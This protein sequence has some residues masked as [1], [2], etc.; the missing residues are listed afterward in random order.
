MEDLA[1]LSALAA[2]PVP[3]AASIA[4][5]SAVVGLLG[6]AGAMAAPRLR[7][8]WLKP[9][10]HVGRG[11]L[12]GWSSVVEIGADAG[13]PMP[14]AIS[15]VNDGESV[16]V[17]L[18]LDGRDNGGLNDEDLLA[19][20]AMRR[21]AFSW[22]GDEKVHVRVWH[23]RE[24]IE[25]STFPPKGGS[26]WVRELIAKHEARMAGTARRTRH[27]MAIT[28]SDAGARDR[29]AKA[30][31]TA[32]RFFRYWGPTV[33]DPRVSDAGPQANALLGFLAALDNPA[34]R[35][36][37]APRSARLG[38]HIAAGDVE[39]VDPDER[40]RNGWQPGLLRWTYG[41]RVKYGHVLAVPDWGTATS[42]ALMADLSTLPGEWTI[43]HH[44]KPLDGQESEALLDHLERNPLARFDRD[45]SEQFQSLR[46][47]IRPESGQRERLCRY[48]QVMYLYGDS[49][50]EAA[51]LRDA[52]E[53]IYLRHRVTALPESDLAGLIWMAQWP[54]F[55]KAAFVRQSRLT[56]LAAAALVNFENQAEGA[57]T[58][59][60]GPS[61]LLILP[62][63]S[64][65]PY[66]LVLHDNPREVASR[67]HT[68]IFGPNGSGKTVFASAM[69]Y[70]ARAHF[71]DLA[72]YCGDRKLGQLVA[73]VAAGAKYVGLLSTVP[74]L[75]PV[76]LN[77]FARQ[78]MDLELVS[79][80]KTLVGLMAGSSSIEVRKAAEAMAHASQKMYVARAPMAHRSL[81]TIAEAALAKGDPVREALA[82]FLPGG[83]Y[84]AV[85]GEGE[86]TASI[87][88]A[89]HVAFD[90][91]SV[92]DDPVVAGPVV[93]DI[94]WLMQRRVRRFGS[95]GL[96]VLDESKKLLGH[97]EFASAAKNWLE[98]LRK[99][100]VA[101]VSMWQRPGQTREVGMEEVLKS[102]TATWIFM[103]DPQATVEQYEGWLTPEEVMVVRGEDPRLAGRSRTVLV[104]KPGTGESV[105]LDADFSHLGPAINL[106]RSDDLA[107]VRFRELLRRD[108]P[109]RATSVYLEEMARRS[110]AA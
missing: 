39:E 1:G 12:Y 33:L 13:V 23:H 25:I 59:G 74:G 53:Q 75:Q 107:T 79:H 22:I 80:L 47:R 6:M 50:E 97:S 5:G 11:E 7:R 63:L 3:W 8:A 30:A 77:P 100:R 48:D 60:W 55:E 76:R 72:I 69:I 83:T 49:P 27:I 96:F 56:T 65:A 51:E 43:V 66:G 94:T 105:I 109:D 15:E 24:R 21:E 57:W 68:V 52:A 29:V 99:D 95:G 67:A 71:P 32:L 16:T 86:E 101:V 19:L 38:V 92:L 35:R 37:V 28:G 4:L 18:A 42:E 14:A 31:R 2:A 110:S 104:K 10:T 90:F 73:M 36:P 34:A 62:T 17:W 88:E 108:G 70:G 82:P 102:Q 64:G 20:R 9:V 26:V 81:G 40:R 106:F 54:G 98:E 85:F 84:D 91:T 87:D 45:A 46:K 89:S 44:V 103:R 58:C 41:A 78:P 61:P 93:K